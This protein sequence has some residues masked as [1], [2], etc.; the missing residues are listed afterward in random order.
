MA[1][2]TP[3]LVWHQQISTLLISSTHMYVFTRA[4]AV[5]SLACKLHVLH[6]HSTAT[7]TQGCTEVGRAPL[8]QFQKIFSKRV[9]KDQN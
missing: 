2:Q 7:T 8:I 1:V 5:A 4:L 6:G 9:S 3:K